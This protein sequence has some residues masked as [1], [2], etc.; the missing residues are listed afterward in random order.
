LDFVFAVLGTLLVVE[1]NADVTNKNL[2]LLG[3]RDVALFATSGWR[4]S[5]CEYIDDG[6]TPWL[7]FPQKLSTAGFRPRY[8]KRFRPFHFIVVNRAPQEHPDLVHSL[9]QP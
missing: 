1:I 8:N 7:N 2:A 4:L 3:S 5:H 6:N 9:G